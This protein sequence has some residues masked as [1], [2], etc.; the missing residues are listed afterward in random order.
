MI[1]YIIILYLAMSNKYDKVAIRGASGLKNLG[2]TCY[3]NSA[4]QCLSA[5]DLLSAYFLD[6]S[7]VSILE[8]NMKEKVATRER[9]KRKL[10]ENA[11][12]EIEEKDIIKEIKKSMVYGY[13]R[14]VKALWSDNVTVEP[15][16]F[17][18]IVGG[19]CSIFNGYQQ[20][21]SQELMNCV[22]DN[23]HE[24]LKR[25]V[26]VKYEIS[27]DILEFRT[28]VKEYQLAIKAGRSPEYKFMILNEYK[29]YLNTHMKEYV[30]NA[31]M[32]QWEKYIRNSYSIVRE[33]FTGVTYTATQCKSCQFV[34]LAFEPFIMYT[35]P[36]PES[37]SSV[38]INDCFKDYV[39]KIEL[40]GKNKYRCDNCKDLRDADQHTY[41]WD[42]PEVLI[43]HLKRFVN[44]EYGNFIRQEKNSTMIKYP[45]NDLDMKTVL[46]PYKSQE[47]INNAKY[48]LFGVVH[49]SGSLNGGHYIATCKNPINNEWY[50]FDDSTVTYIPQDKVEK[51]VV[52]NSAY[53]LFYKK[54]YPDLDE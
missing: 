30:Y 26:K 23:I 32:E 53:I 9:K 24:E 17:K 43:I 42:T 7:F 25:S 40:T 6:K 52:R 3:M 36:I 22:I 28:K 14:L 45:I 13:Y 11:T 20:N 47:T 38:D 29:N 10:D 54:K 41:V 4:L 8:D 18:S 33:I 51:E 50:E 27:N 35:L 37:S 16:E 34:S 49:Q 12:V 39:N 1:H 48:D 46:S 44:K 19:H 15:R 21:D 2:N 5:T 31:S